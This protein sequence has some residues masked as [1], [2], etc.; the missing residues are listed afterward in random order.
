[1]TVR[2]YMDMTPKIGDRAFIDT[3]AVVIGN[4]DLG[5]D[6]SV[7]PLSV[8]RG[9]V[10]SIRIGD[11]TNIQDGSVLHCTP[12]FATEVGNFCTIGHNAHLEGCRVLDGGLVGSAAVALHGAVIGEYALVGAGAVVTGGTIIPA[13]ALAIGTPAKVRENAA[14]RESIHSGMLSYIQRGKRYRAELR[15]LD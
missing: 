10:H 3:S 15:R 6:S 7:W 5:V 11:R 9:D 14:D 2:S 12:E 4:V 8:V 13:G 1:M